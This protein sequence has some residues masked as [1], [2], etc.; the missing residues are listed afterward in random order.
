MRPSTWAMTPLTRGGRAGSSGPAGPGSLVPVAQNGPSGNLH[1]ISYS[2]RGHQPSSWAVRVG[3]THRGL[4]R[5]PSGYQMAHRPR[6]ELMREG[7]GH[8][9]IRPEVESN[10]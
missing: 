5:L 3:L 9:Q 7:A 10:K 1:A 8:E 2:R 6:S 4:I